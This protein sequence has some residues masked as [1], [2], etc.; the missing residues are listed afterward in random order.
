ML[1]TA[2]SQRIQYQSRSILQLKS[3]VHQWRSS[4]FQGRAT[5][6]AVCVATANADDGVAGAG[7]LIMRSS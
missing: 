4:N 2:D 3:C 1:I 5:S 7:E 6:A